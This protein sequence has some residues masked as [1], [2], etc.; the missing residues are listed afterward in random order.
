MYYSD[1]R[2]ETNPTIMFLST[3]TDMNRQGTDKD[4]TKSKTSWSGN[5]LVTRT[6]LSNLI[7]G[8]RLEFEVVDEWKLSKDG[9]VLTQTSKTIFRQDSANAVFIPASRPDSKKVYARL[10]D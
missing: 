5:K 6:T 10:R 1:G 4:T 7:A 9:K 3:G 2:G 8:R